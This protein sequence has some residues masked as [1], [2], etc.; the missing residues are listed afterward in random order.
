MAKLAFSDTSNKDGIIQLCEDYT[1][2]ADGKI[3]GTTL[4]LQKFTS[5][6][7]LTMSELWHDIFLSSGNWKY[8]DG[9]H[10]DLPQATTGLTDTVAT[11]ALPDE[12][13]TVERIEVKDESGN[14]TKIHPLSQYDIKVAIDEYRNGDGTPDQYRLLD[15]TIELF[16]APNYTQAASLKVYFLRAGV[17]FTT[18]DTT[19]APGFAS[20]Y[21]E[22]V[23]IGASLRWLR[24][25]RPGQADTVQ[26]EREYLE[27]RSRMKQFYGRRFKDKPVV[28]RRKRKVSRFLN[29]RFITG[30][31]E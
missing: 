25:H 6:V 11:Y 10:N 27:W 20:E 26:K 31:F 2:L 21:H 29:R 24:T 3:S 23:P 22:A 13:L 14:W 17:L 1:G 28:L 19:E 8:D 5:F 9:N 4:L 16:P 18:A 15:D 30:E 12:A 7:N